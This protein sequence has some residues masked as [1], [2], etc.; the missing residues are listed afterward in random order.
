MVS[1]NSQKIQSLLCL[2]DGGGVDT[3][4]QVVL[5][6]HA[7]KLE[8]GNHLHTDPVDEQRLNDSLFPSEVDQLLSFC[9]VQDQ[10]VL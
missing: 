1:E 7:Q 5:Y 4:G 3:L 6:L 8:V 9:S 10:V 2:F